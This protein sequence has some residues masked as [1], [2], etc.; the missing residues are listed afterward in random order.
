MFRA[1]NKN[2]EMENHVK[3]PGGG[4]RG[5]DGDSGAALM[6][7]LRA[8]RAYTA[9]LRNSLDLL[10][11]ELELNRVNSESL[12]DTNQSIQK[13]ADQSND[14]RADVGQSKNL[15]LQLKRRDTVD[16]LM[17]LG[18]LA[19]FIAVVVFIVTSRIT[20][21]LLIVWR[22]ASAPVHFAISLVG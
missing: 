20:G 7:Q 18:A 11:K 21:I 17:T 12:D 3:L 4:G 2:R 10:Q 16:K 6:N 22:I 14:Y 15:I 9:S 8:A 5:G 1:F 13:I 19:V